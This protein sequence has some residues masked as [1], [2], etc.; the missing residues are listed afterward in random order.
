MLAATT[1]RTKRA[2]FRVASKSPGYPPIFRVSFDN[3]P[4][5]SEPEHGT[6]V[7]K[8][9]LPGLGIEF[10]PIKQLNTTLSSI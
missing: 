7:Y 10:N 2:L 9:N 5:P 4:V 8:S 6:H 3:H 1:R